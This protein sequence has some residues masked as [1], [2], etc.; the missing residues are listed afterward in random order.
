MECANTFSRPCTNSLSG[1]RLAVPCAVPVLKDKLFS[2]FGTFQERACHGARGQ[3]LSAYEAQ[4]REISRSVLD[5][6]CD[7]F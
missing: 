7:P 6:A 4:R 3:S 5:T 1:T 2:N